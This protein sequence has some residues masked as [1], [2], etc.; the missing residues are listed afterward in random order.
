MG[1]KNYSEEGQRRGEKLDQIVE[2]VRELPDAF[3]EVRPMAS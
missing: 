2:C 3:G 1:L